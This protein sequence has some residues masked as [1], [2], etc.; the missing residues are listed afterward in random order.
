MGADLH[1]DET[2][3]AV[4][5][6]VVEDAKAVARA[7]VDV[8]KAQATARVRGYKRSA[9]FFGVAAVIGFAAAI[10]LVVGLLL[11]IATLI[12]PGFATLVVVIVF[13]A[14]A[15]LLAVLGTKQLP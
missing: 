14:I 12:G 2:L 5:G 10:A 3:S 9:I 4:V 8:V 11:T 7:E 13:V 15:G 6:R 1:R